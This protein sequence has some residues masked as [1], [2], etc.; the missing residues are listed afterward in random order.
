MN[1]YAASLDRPRKLL[2]EYTP[3]SKG[4][5]YTKAERN[6]HSAVP[7]IRDKNQAISILDNSVLDLG[8]VLDDRNSFLALES[9]Q[10]AGNKP[11]FSGY[12]SYSNQYHD[13]DVIKLSGDNLSKS[14]R[15]GKSHPCVTFPFRFM[16]VSNLSYDDV[17][18]AAKYSVTNIYIPNEGLLVKGREVLNYHNALPA[19]EHNFPELSSLYRSIH[20]GSISFNRNL[21]L[22]IDVVGKYQP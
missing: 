3:N 12:V 4:K 1:P 20:N 9:V 13:L 19:L 5:F 6:L 22:N 10:I 15:F 11:L 16:K 21:S 8:L 18:E 7:L 14:A 17:W 2:V